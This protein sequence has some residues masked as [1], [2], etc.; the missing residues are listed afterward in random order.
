MDYVLT[1]RELAYLIK[2]ARIDFKNLPISAGQ[3]LFNSGSGAAAIY[4]ASGGVMESAL[5][6]A[7]FLLSDKKNRNKNKNI[8]KI[9]DSCLE[10]TAVRGLDG[11]KEASIKIAGKNLKVAVVNGLGNFSKI[12]PKLKKYHY[13]EVMACPGGCIGGGGQPI[14]TTREICQKRIAGLYK[15]DKGRNIRRAHENVMMQT[16]YQ[17]VKDR[18][19]LSKLI[20]TKF[21]KSKKSLF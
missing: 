11:L 16:Y 7:V 2:K 8:N 18:Q 12:L 20:Y 3:P 10:F 13:V 6:T 5:R 4:G 21:K 19:L 17:W 14:P 1:T 9:L 15:I